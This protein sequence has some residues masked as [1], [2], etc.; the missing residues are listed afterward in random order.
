MTTHTVKFSKG[1]MAFLIAMSI[2]VLATCAGL[3]GL[4]WKAVLS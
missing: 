4:L 3:V 1:V 2:L